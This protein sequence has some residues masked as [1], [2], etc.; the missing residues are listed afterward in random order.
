VQLLN[1]VPKR[2]S[3]HAASFVAD[4]LV[5]QMHQ[6]LECT[7]TMWSIA[8]CLSTIRLRLSLYVL[9]IQGY[10]EDY[11][12]FL[13]CKAQGYSGSCVQAIRSLT[14]DAR[15]E[16][17]GCGGGAPALTLCSAPVFCYSVLL[18]PCGVS[19]MG[20]CTSGRNIVVVAASMLL[21]LARV[22]RC[23]GEIPALLRP[24]EFLPGQCLGLCNGHW[25][26]ITRR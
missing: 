26:P 21:H 2:R 17:Q 12:S 18:I 7:L 23:R 6:L 8:R 5:W 3:N 11:S 14:S 24:T 16:R 19:H 22:F 20:K 25:P 4:A 9:N 13:M 1:R 15:A 10:I